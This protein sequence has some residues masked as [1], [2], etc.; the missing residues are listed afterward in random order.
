MLN[1][2]KSWNVS[3]ITYATPFGEIATHGSVA[4]S[5]APPE[6]FDTPGMTTWRHAPR[7]KTEAT[8]PREP[9]LDHR[10]C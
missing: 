8:V 1:V 3:V 10:S 6:H 7:K 5:N 9:P 2:G 4:R